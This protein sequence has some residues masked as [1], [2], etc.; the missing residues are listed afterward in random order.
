MSSSASSAATLATLYERWFGPPETAVNLRS[1]VWHFSEPDALG[2]AAPLPPFPRTYTGSCAHLMRV[3]RDAI[4]RDLLDALGGGAND[5][6]ATPIVWGVSACDFLG[7]AP[8]FVVE[9]S[10]D[11]RARRSWPVHRCEHCATSAARMRVHN[12]RTKEGTVV[13]FTRAAHVH[14]L[15]AIL[16][17]A[18]RFDDD[19]EHRNSAIMHQVAQRCCTMIAHGVRFLGATA[20]T[21]ASTKVRFCV[22]RFDVSPVPSTECVQFDVRIDVACTTHDVAGNEIASQRSSGAF[23]DTAS[24]D[25]SLHVS[26]GDDDDNT[27]CSSLSSHKGVCDGDRARIMIPATSTTPET[28]RDAVLAPASTLPPSH[29]EPSLR[30]TRRFSMPPAMEAILQSTAT[31]TATTISKSESSHSV[32]E[33]VAF[34]ISISLQ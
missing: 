20:T 29:R 5:D 25:A 32:E 24:G 28:V 31:E 18:R 27:S 12:T 21:S 30:R 22:S 3:L 13:V 23:V 26:D 11:D 34:L 7:E 19:G 1:R 17:E 6:G 4:A 8:R 16:D 14:S 15:H 33:D 9:F 10:S 2:R